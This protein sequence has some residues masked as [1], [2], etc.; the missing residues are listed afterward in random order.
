VRPAVSVGRTEAL[1][2]FNNY[3]NHLTDVNNNHV[4]QFDLDIYFDAPQ[5]TESDRYILENGIPPI[6]NHFDLNYDHL[7]GDNDSFIDQ[8]NIDEYLHHDES[9]QP[10]PEV[11]SS[12]SL[13]ESTASLQ[14][15]LGASSY[16]C[17]DGGNAVT[18]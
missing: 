8:F 4:S 6:A 2:G 9:N 18:V 17:D 14:P 12:D 11:Q 16:G 5:P 10:A 13:A 7:A 1:D 3:S 15:Q